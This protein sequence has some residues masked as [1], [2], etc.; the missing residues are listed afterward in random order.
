VLF[1]KIFARIL[2]SGCVSFVSVQVVEFCR[3]S[4]V[5]IGLWF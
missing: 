5:A 2:T 3:S 1:S 4:D